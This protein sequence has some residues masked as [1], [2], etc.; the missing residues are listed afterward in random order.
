M[1]TYTAADLANIRACI[2][3]GVLRTRFADGREVTY[4]DLDQLMA[5]ERVIAAAVEMAEAA[6]SG[7]VRRKFAGFRNGC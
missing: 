4:Q 5:A 1:T 6:T 2:A 3:S 7:V